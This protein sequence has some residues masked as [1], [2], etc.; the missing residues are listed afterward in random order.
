M[1]NEPDPATGA[2]PVAVSIAGPDLGDRFGGEQELAQ[3][4]VQGRIPSADVF[5]GHGGVLF[6]VVPVVGQDGRQAGV[7]GGVHPLVVPVDR[8][9][10]LA[11]RGHG[12]VVIHGRLTEELPLLV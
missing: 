4:G 5:E 2:A 3:L 11:Q 8:L 10:L 7:G 9:E 6:L 1:P 12:P